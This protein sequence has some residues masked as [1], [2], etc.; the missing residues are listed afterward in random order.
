MPTFIGLIASLVLF[1]G[2]MYLF[3]FAFQVEG[4]EAW[5]FFAGIILVAIA[6]FIPTVLL[7]R[8]KDTWKS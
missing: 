3:G 1:L 8:S 2:G 7:G 4:Y 5:I 6:M